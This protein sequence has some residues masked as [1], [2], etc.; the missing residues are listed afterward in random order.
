[1]LWQ[2]KKHLCVCVVTL[3]FSKIFR[4]ENPNSVEMY[5]HRSNFFKLSSFLLVSVV[6]LR[7]QLEHK[8]N[9]QGKLFFLHAKHLI[10]QIPIKMTDSPVKFCQETVNVTAP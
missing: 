10:A 8:Q 3:N 6:N 9:R 2:K 5:K 4:I 1:M 7:D